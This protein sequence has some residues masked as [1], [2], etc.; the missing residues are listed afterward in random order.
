LKYIGGLFLLIS[1]GT[2]L[3]VCP[4]D[5]QNQKSAVE[6]LYKDH[7]ANRYICGEWRIQA[8]SARRLTQL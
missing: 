4:E 5:T 8:R 6:I 1:M 3:A 7:D 2:A